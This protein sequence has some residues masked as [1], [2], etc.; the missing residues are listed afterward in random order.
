MERRIGVVARIADTVTVEIGLVG[1][2]DG[3]AIVVGGATTVA[4]SVTAAAR[5]A[6]AP[7]AG[8]G[9]AADVAVVAHRAVGDGRR[10]ARARLLAHA[11]VALVGDARAIDRG[12]GDAETGRAVT[13][14]DTVAGETVATARVVGQRRIEIHVVTSRGIRR[15]PARPHTAGRD[16][17]RGLRRAVVV[18]EAAADVGDTR[19]R[20][21]DGGQR[22]ERGLGGGERGADAVGDDDA[23]RTRRIGRPPRQRTVR[24]DEAA[25]T[26]LRDRIWPVIEQRR[27][28]RRHQV[29]FAGTDPLGLELVLVALRIAVALIVDA[30]VVVR[31]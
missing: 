6:G 17:G 12:A 22:D 24:Q 21:H 8:I 28:V 16:V 10:H 26:D 18:D 30:R 15:R 1:V 7:V 31:R 14:L 2:G 19:A 29:R 20:A 5:N 4:V 3:R 9:H 23:D 11:G 25:E 27:Q 13:G